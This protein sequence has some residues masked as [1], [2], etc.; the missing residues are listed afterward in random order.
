MIKYKSITLFV[1]GDKMELE[2]KWKECTEINM[3]PKE[4]VKF[5]APK[6][7]KEQPFEDVKA[8]R[9][10]G[11]LTFE[12]FLKL[13]LCKSPRPKPHYLKNKPKDVENITRKAFKLARK[14]PENLHDIIS[15][16]KEL[17]GVSVPVASY[18]LTAWNPKDY[19]TYDFRMK[20]ILQKCEGFE[21]PKTES[22]LEW[23]EAELRLLRKWKKELG[24]RTCRQ[25]E[26]A[27]W[28]FQQMKGD[29]DEIH[30][31]YHF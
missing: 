29:C 18:I 14:D 22:N 5:V 21:E 10:R 4:F 11:Y 30:K 26:Y 7:G 1:L 24:I 8:F 9:D 16:L 12:E 23:Y 28:R 25:I 3:K 13:A 2:I 31:S 6:V 19:G 20:K 27:L 15:T 17:K